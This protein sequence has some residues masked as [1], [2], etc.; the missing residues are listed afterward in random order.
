MGNIIGIAILCFCLWM[1]LQI[2]RLEERTTLMLRD[3][4]AVSDVATGDHF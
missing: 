1:G 3:V 4:E 2:H